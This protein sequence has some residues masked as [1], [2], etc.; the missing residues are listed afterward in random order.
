MWALNICM[1]AIMFQES[2]HYSLAL[3]TGL[4]R[5]QASEARAHFFDF[6]TISPTVFDTA[7]ASGSD[8]L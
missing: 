2:I 1:P 4:F 3:E 8:S 5:C 6:P 7:N